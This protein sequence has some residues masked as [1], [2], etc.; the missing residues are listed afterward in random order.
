MQWR[1]RFVSIAWPVTN[2]TPA[3]NRPALVLGEPDSQGDLQLLKVSG[4]R[5]HQASVSVDAADLEE[6]SRPL[7]QLCYVGVDQAIAVH[8]SLVKPIGA[9]LTAKALAA[10]HRAR[11]LA[12]SRQCS[13]LMHRQHLPADHPDRTSWN[14]GPI[15]YAGRV[16]GPEEVEAAVGAS[17]DFWLT[18]GAEGATF[19]LELAAFLGVHSSLLVN[20]GSSANLIALSMLGSP[21]IAS[22]RRLRPGDEVITCAAGF[23]TTV[24]PIVQNGCVPVFVDADPVTANL[25]VDQLEA[26]YTPGRTRAVMVAHA[27]GNPFDIAAVLQF[28]RKYNLWLIEDNCDALGS[29]YSMPR[30]LAQSLGFSSN[31]PGL[32]EG[33]D[34]VVRYSG[35]WG[36]LSTQSFFPAHHI[37]TGEGGAVNVVQPD[38]RLR[39]IAESLRDWGRDCWCPTGRDNTCGKRYGWQLAELP[40]GYDHKYIYSHFGYNLKPLDLQAAIGRQQIQRLPDFGAARRRNWQ[41]L[42]RGLAD[43]GADLC[44]SLPTHATGWTPQGFTWDDSG[45]RSDPSWFGYLMRVQPTAAVSREALARSLENAQIGTRMLFGGN[46][47]RQPAFVQLAQE[48]PDALR[49]VGSAMPGADLL[50]QQ[51]LFLGTYPGL[52][53]PMLEQMQ[54]ALR[55]ALEERP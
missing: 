54:A 46:L 32:D 48:R 36:D 30:H 31:S 17:I 18:L 44:F 27:L 43:L 7:K 28:C 13:E 14:G 21:L 9:Q 12:S 23:P 39:R 55:S 45:C 49:S 11:A 26:A 24:A 2:Q 19:E 51:A 15:P 29:T 50:M 20:S 53:K 41:H 42:R 6:G 34:R 35:S 4:K 5:G 10:V 22:E 40:H 16:F 3:K 52:T 33:P 37:T 25:R 38:G 47:L 1:G 8:A